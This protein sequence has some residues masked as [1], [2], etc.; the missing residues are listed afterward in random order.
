MSRKFEDILNECLEG[1]LRG[2]PVK[3]YLARYPEHAGELERLLRTALVAAEASRLRPSPE[4]KAAARYRV[5]SAFGRAAEARRRR[6]GWSR[7]WAMAV[8]AVALVCTSGIGT[9]LAAEQ[10]LPGEPLYQVK[11]AREQVELTLARDDVS[12][13][14]LYVELAEKR[15]AEAERLA[16]KV[17]QASLQGRDMARAQELR[18]EVD[19]SAAQQLI[20][21]Q[22]LLKTAPDPAR[23]PIIRAINA[24]WQHYERALRCISNLDSSQLGQIG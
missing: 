13:A 20:P 16:G 15:V 17:E 22:D 4:F 12:K 3:G 6:F 23:D 21:L 18:K 10:S 7:R 11:M 19:Q 5:M 1:V 2:D 24:T 14:K 9:V 8:V